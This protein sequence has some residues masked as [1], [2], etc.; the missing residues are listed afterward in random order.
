MQGRVREGGD[1][2]AA[3]SMECKG[4]TSFSSSKAPERRNRLKSI[5]LRVSG[6]SGAVAGCFPL[7]P[8]L[9]AVKDRSPQAVLLFCMRER[10]QCERRRRQ[11]TRSGPPDVWRIILTTCKSPIKNNITCIK[12]IQD[13]RGLAT[14]VLFKED[15]R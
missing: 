14:L 2:L 12:A 11:P 13:G 8:I 3:M 7:L 1:H 9:T 4:H 6:F 10:A 15:V 5:V